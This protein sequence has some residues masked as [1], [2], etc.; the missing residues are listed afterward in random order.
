MNNFRLLLITV[1]FLSCCGCI[2]SGKPV[3]GK[4]AETPS[5]RAVTEQMLSEVR[6]AVIVYSHR[7]GKP[8]ASLGTL[9]GKW[10]SE[11]VRDG[12]GNPIT[13]AVGTDSTVRLWS[14]GSDNAI[15]GTGDAAD[16]IV[17]FQ[18]FASPTTTASPLISTPVH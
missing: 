11:K 4:G 3:A 16:I 13:Y 6:D 17:V 5:P 1:F 10:D 14:F 2:T 7:R 8:P 9:Q 15:G 12:W 18:P